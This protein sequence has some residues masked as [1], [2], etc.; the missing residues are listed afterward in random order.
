MWKRNLLFFLL[1][2]LCTLWLCLILLYR[3][4]KNHD[5]ESSVKVQAPRS[6]S[7]NSLLDT[8]MY[9]VWMDDYHSLTIDSGQLNL[10][11]SISTLIL[12]LEN[13]QEERNEQR[14]VLLKPY[15]NLAFEF[16]TKNKEGKI[17][18]R[19]EDLSVQETFLSMHKT[20]KIKGFKNYILFLLQQSST[21]D[22][23]EIQ[24][25]K[26]KRAIEN[27]YAAKAGPISKKRIPAVRITN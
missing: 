21:K 4:Q 19:L 20:Y 9:K 12:K 26:L 1:L 11:G 18:Y 14:I 16:I 7:W 22:Q 15:E 13:G 3:N 23:D 5:F 24:L 6:S 10:L 8:S 17:E 27:T 25:V 2:I